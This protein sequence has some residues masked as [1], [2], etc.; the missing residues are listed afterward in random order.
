MHFLNHSN[1]NPKTHLNKSKLHLNRN[2]YEKLGKNSVNFIRNNYTWFLESNKKANIDIG[3]SSTSSTLN[4]KS[5]IDNKTVEYITNIGLKSLRIRNLNEIVVGHLNIN[6]IRNKVNFF[7]YQV[8]GNI[9][10]LMISE[11]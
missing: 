8:Q 10:L 11:N 9:D 6:L 7:A 3:V 2:G 1:I 4:E 5:E